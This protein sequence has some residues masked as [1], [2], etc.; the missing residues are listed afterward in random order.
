MDV[1]CGSFRKNDFDGNT[2]IIKQFP[3]DTLKGRFAYASYIE[4][5]VNGYFNLGIWNNLYRLDFLKSN[6]IYCNTNYRIFEDRLFTFMVVLHASSVSYIH[7]V[8]Y[9]YNDVP[10]SIC[11]QNN[12]NN[13]LQIYRSII[14]SV[15]ET[16][17]DFLDSNKDQTFPYGIRFL[18]DYICMSDGLLKKCL[19]LDASRRDKKNCLSGCGI[20]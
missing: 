2:Y 19:E 16:V 3:E 5:Y 13:F 7:E 4:K 12:D 14:V 11:H 1:V 20:P 6:G 15:F 18:L 17:K 9:N 8:T 10:T